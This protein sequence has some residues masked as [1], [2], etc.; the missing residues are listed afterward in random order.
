MEK[1]RGIVCINQILQSPLRGLRRMKLMVWC[2]S[3]VN[4]LLIA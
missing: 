1:I 4:R 2:C 3:I